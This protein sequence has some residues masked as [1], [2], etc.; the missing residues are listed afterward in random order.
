MN[1]KLKSLLLG[2]TMMV[3]LVGCATDGTDT[4]ELEQL[5]IN[6]EETVVEEETESVEEEVVEEELETAEEPTASET[7]TNDALDNNRLI[8]VDGGNTSG[9]RE[10]NVKVNIGHGNR[11]YWAYTNEHGQ[12]VKVTAKQIVVQDDATEDVNS[13]GRYYSKMADVQGVGADTG[14]DRGHIIADSLGGVANAYNITPQEATLNRHGD[15]A[16]M[17]KVIRDAGGATDFVAIITYPNT[18][19]QVPSHY[20]YTYTIKG[21]RVTDSFANGSP[22]ELNKAMGLTGSNTESSRP[23][24][25]EETQ[26][27]ESGDGV[28]VDENGNGLIK[29]SNSGIY[30]TP[31]SSYYD[32][33]TNPK[34]MFKSVQEAEDAGYRAP[35]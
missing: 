28:W 4:S 9:Y 24:A 6:T 13:D 30:H 35:K 26:S 18:E 27:E 11:E 14:Y 7:T 31:E 21:N 20:E 10:A 22:D 16:Y 1:K 34:Q 3:S 19:T 23:E 8:E 25:K 32:R 2:L 15:Q 17:E 29:G 33:T 12:L 5:G